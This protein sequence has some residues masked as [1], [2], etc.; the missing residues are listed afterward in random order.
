MLHKGT[1]QYLHVRKRLVLAQVIPTHILF[2]GF[3]INKLQEI[4]LYI[5]LILIRKA[6]KNQKNVECKI[7]LTAC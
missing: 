5:Y 6:E 7:L 4:E 2:G 3:S 1:H